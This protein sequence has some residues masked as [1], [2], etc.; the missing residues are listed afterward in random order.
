MKTHLFA[1]Q[2]DAFA[3]DLILFLDHSRAVGMVLISLQNTYL[4]ASL[5]P[6][7]ASNIITH[8]MCI[9]PI[10]GTAPHS[11]IHMML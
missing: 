10:P 8:G 7:L 1:R 4:L 2:S 9:S 5:R 11:T 3:K 6:R